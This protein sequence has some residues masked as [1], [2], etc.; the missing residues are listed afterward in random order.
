MIKNKKN[1]N[2]ATVSIA[3]L[4]TTQSYNHA[5]NSFSSTY[6]KPYIKDFI[7]NP[8]YYFKNNKVNTRQN[9]DLLLITQGWSKYN[10]TTNLIM[11]KVRNQSLPT[12][13]P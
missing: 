3:V 11:T 9:L 1:T 8:S 4:T 5:H 7:E 12:K 6:L 13:S 10:W 2:D